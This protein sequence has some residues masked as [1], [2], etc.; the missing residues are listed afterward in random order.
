MFVFRWR[1]LEMSPFLLRR[2]LF[3]VL[4]LNLACAAF[5]RAPVAAMPVNAAATQQKNHPVTDD[6]ITDDVRLKLGGDPDVKGG[7]IKVD[8]KQ[9]VVTLSGIVETAKQKAKA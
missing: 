8:I 5:E 2:L 7:A 9:G 1:I 3:A 4:M 6:V